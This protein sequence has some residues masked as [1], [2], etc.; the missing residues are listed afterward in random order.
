MKK[1]YFAA[2]GRELHIDVPLS[3]V[4]IDYRPQGMIADMI[5]PVVEVP[6]ITG[7]IPV[8]DRADVLRVENT[9]RAPGVP[10]NLVTR[11]VSS[12]SYVCKNYA[13]RRSITIEDRTNADPIYVQKLFNGGAQ[14][15]K[16]KLSLDWER[17]VARK[18]CSGSNVGSYSAVSSAWTD[19]TNS[20]PLANLNTAIDNVQDAT[21]YRPNRI[22]FGE[23]A[24]RYLR[25]HSGVLNLIFGQ[26]NGGGYAT[27]DAVA[28]LLEIP[29]VLIG[30]AYQ[31][32]TEEG[33]AESLS[34]IWNDNVL[35]YY[36]PDNASVDDPAFMYSFRWGA[37]GIPN[38]QVE[39]H[40]YDTKSKSE[41]IE[42]G[43]YQD[44]KITGKSYGFLL[45][46]VTSST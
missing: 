17:R 46:A 40:P 14:F 44:E 2:T 43:Y 45:T 15:L 25:R 16:T 9:L 42:L 37:A 13:L 6:N 31:N 10:A 5:S 8:F 34:Q 22:I 26:N 33:K 29:T 41:D 21:G 23:K 20:N 19:L 36:S 12:D 32:T 4:A 7:Q 11:D 1:V 28:N 3:N 38:M 39:R 18:V 24:W 35:V 27:P 30:R